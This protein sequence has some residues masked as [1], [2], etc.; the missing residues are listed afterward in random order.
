MCQRDRDSTQVPPTPPHSALDMKADGKLHQGHLGTCGCGG[1]GGGGVRESE[2]AARCMHTDQRWGRKW[3][4]VVRTKHTQSCQVDCLL[5]VLP[6]LWLCS[7][8]S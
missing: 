5:P 6:V 4:G 7:P 1:D 3:V 2:G 8:S